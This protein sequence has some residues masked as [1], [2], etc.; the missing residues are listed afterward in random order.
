[1]LCRGLPV[2]RD[3]R[4][5]EIGSVCVCVVCVCSPANGFRV[6]CRDGINGGPSPLVLLLLLDAAGAVLRLFLGA[7]DL[8]LG[9]LGFWGWFFGGCRWL[10]EALVQSWGRVVPVAYLWRGAVAW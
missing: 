3:T 10:W 4:D 8:V 5:R 6:E 9:V 2:S 7:W 1:M